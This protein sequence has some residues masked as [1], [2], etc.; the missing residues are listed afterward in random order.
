MSCKQVNIYA[1][2]GIIKCQSMS[3][4]IALESNISSD[5]RQKGLTAY[6]NDWYIE[7]FALKLTICFNIFHHLTHFTC[8]CL[9]TFSA[10]VEKSCSVLIK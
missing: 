9:L 8:P 7:P 5:S 4:N 6:I 1:M 3:Y 2:H 10:D